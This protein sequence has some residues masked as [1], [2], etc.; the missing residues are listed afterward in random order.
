MIQRVN[1]LGR[2]R[3]NQSC[4]AI[5]VYDGEPRTFDAEINIADVGFPEA[6]S[7]VIEGTSAGSSVVQRFDCGTVGT[8]RSLVAKFLI[9]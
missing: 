2:K 8:L 6:A 5:E 9:S 1:S 7:V 4:V 3:I